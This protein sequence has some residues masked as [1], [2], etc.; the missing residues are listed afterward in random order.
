MRLFGIWG[1]LWLLLLGRMFLVQRAVLM[2]LI[3]VLSFFDAPLEFVRLD[4]T[5]DNSVIC[6]FAGFI[7]KRI[8][9]ISNITDLCFHHSKRLPIKGVC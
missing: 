5:A 6:L 7:P 2:C 1:L 9:N 4:L 3:F 8:L